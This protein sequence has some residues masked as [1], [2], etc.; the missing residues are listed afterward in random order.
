MDHSEYV[1]FAESIENQ[2]YESIKNSFSKK[3]QEISQIAVDYFKKKFWYEE[4]GEAK[5]WSKFEDEV[6]DACYKKLRPELL[7]V[8]ETFRYLKTFKNHSFA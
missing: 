2:V 4:N 5:I 7:E 8:F 1:K 3:I 6:I